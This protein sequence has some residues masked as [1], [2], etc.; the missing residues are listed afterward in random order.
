MKD[1]DRPANGQSIPGMEQRGRGDTPVVD[2]CTVGAADVYKV[3]CP[4]F[5]RLKHGVL[6]G[7]PLEGQ[8]DIV[9]LA[10]A[11]VEGGLAGQRHGGKAPPDSSRIVRMGG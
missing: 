10:A 3:Q 1:Q 9:F 7:H 2:E 6:P 4:G 5:I 8:Y 11:Y